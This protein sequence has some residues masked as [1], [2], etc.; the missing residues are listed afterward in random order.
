MISG[1]GASLYSLDGKERKLESIVNPRR[2]TCLVAC[3]GAHPWQMWQPRCSAR[4]APQPLEMKRWR[5]CA[6]GTSS[7]KLACR[8]RKAVAVRLESDP[9]PS[10]VPAYLHAC[11]CILLEAFSVPVTLLGSPETT[12]KLAQSTHISQIL[13]PHFLTQESERWC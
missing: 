4:A 10:P 13:Q 3:P 2:K 1:I 11:S 8:G 7:L 6:G 9:L 5:G 12:R